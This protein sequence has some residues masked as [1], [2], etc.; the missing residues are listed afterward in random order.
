MSNRLTGHTYELAPSALGRQHLAQ[1][2]V[3]LS[4]EQDA[5]LHCAGRVRPFP[6]GHSFHVID[7]VLK[8]FS[9]QHTL[10]LNST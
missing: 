9:W 5:T 10:I 3:N 6:D 7:I 4:T 1:P 8:I 2:S